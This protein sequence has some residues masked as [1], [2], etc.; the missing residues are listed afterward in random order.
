MFRIFLH[1]LLIG[2][3]LVDHLHSYSLLIL[4]THLC[5]VLRLVDVERFCVGTISTLNIP[6]I[7]EPNFPIQIFEKLCLHLQDLSAVDLL[8]V[9]TILK[10]LLINIGLVV[11]PCQKV[12]I[13]LHVF[14]KVVIDLILRLR[15]V[16]R[17]KKVDDYGVAAAAVGLNAGLNQFDVRPNL[18]FTLRQKLD[19]LLVLKNFYLSRDVQVF[20]FSESEYEYI[21]L[22]LRHLIFPFAAT[23]ALHTLTEIARHLH[24]FARVEALS[25]R[26]IGCKRCLLLALRIFDTLLH[27]QTL[28]A[29]YL[30]IKT[31]TSLR[32]GRRRIQHFV[33]NILLV[34]LPAFHRPQKLLPHLL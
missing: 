29:I 11:T 28:W 34:R 1:L 24:R 18:R 26:F 6:C 30:A 10:T 17:G 32:I 23:R 13:G 25:A 2:F 22:P 16:E 12:N 31:L 19:E 7:K 33:L 27:A 8:G 5:I 3:Q 15:L 20:V 4:L 21:L 9:V 14:V